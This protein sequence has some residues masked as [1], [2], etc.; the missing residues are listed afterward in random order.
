MNRNSLICIYAEILIYFFIREAFTTTIF[1]SFPKSYYIRKWYIIELISCRK[2]Y[3]YEGD[4]VLF[5]KFTHEFNLMFMDVLNWKCIRCT[6]FCI[7][8]YRNPLNDTNIVNRTFLLKVCKTN[9]SCFFI[10][11]YRGNRCWNFLYKSKLL[12]KIFLI[13][14]VN[15]FF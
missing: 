12:L 2:I 9:L 8:T 10:Y 11:F 13:C 15:Y 5:L 4:S 6:F 14:A 1:T 7:K 3:N